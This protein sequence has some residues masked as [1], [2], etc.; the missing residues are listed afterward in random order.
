MQTKEDIPHPK[1]CVGVDDSGWSGIKRE[2]RGE[3][4][5]KRKAQ[6]NE[7]EQVKAKEQTNQAKMRLKIS[8][9]A[10]THYIAP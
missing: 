5:S 3:K 2:D 4:K 9:I 7:R 10:H 6:V 1:L 8:N